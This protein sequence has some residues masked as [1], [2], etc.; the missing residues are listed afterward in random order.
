MKSGSEKML[1]E[2]STLGCRLSEQIL[3]SALWL[4]C[5]CQHVFSSTGSGLLTTLS[6]LSE[7]CTGIPEG[8]G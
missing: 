1:P 7:P 2:S 6:I 4:C 5:D 3:A 8:L